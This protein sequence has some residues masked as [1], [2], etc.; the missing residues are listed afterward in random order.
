MYASYYGLTALPFQLTPDCQ[1]FFRSAGHTR[2]ISHLVYGLEQQ[3]GFII[4]TGDVG[5]GKTTLVELLCTRLGRAHHVIVRIM[6]TLLSPDD[7]LRLVA[8]G[9]GVEGADKASVLR[10]VETALRL[11]RAAGRQALLVVDEAQGLTVGGL[12]MLRMLSNMAQDGRSLLQ[13][14]LLGQPEFRQTLARPELN[15]LR[16]R[17]LASTHLGPL[18]PDEIQAYVEHRLAAVGWAG[19]PAWEPAA[20]ERIHAHTGGVPRRINRLCG[21][22]LLFGALEKAGVITAAMVDAT[23]AELEADIGSDAVAAPVPALDNRMET[24]E[25]RL[26][27]L[28]TLL[29]GSNRGAA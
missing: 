5:A 1:F 3:E 7:L 2:A 18:P 13:I 8:S 17:V 27:R 10:R 20:F 29:D 6:T 24:L 23:A 26:D 4:I 28:F 22:V 11:V 14:V 9:F 21:R 15:Q 12:E 19:R 16:Q 25:G